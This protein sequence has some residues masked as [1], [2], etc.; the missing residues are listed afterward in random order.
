MGSS[1]IVETVTGKLCL[2][3]GF[4]P[5]SPWIGQLDPGL[6]SHVP[7][8]V[9]KRPLARLVANSLGFGGTNVSLVLGRA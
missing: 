5:G 7:I 8:D 2:E 1:G 6:R 9:A 4:L 3:Q